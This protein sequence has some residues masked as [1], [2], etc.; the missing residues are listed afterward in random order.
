MSRTKLSK[1]TLER[2]LVFAVRLVQQYEDIIRR[3]REL[4]EANSRKKCQT[5]RH[6]YPC[7]TIRHLDGEQV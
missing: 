3:L 5:C 7:P 1:N 2:D 6:P 4:H